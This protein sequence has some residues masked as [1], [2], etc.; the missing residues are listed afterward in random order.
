MLMNGVFDALNGHFYAEGISNKVDERDK[1]NRTYKEVKFVKLNAMLDVLD[2]TEETKEKRL[3]H[4]IDSPS[5]P[6][7]STTT[8]NNNY[9]V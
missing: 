5:E 8:S 1:Y 6:F 9:K 3:K 7:C 2:I 4:S